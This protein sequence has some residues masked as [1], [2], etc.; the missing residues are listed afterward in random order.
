MRSLLN[1]LILFP[2]WAAAQI[3]NNTKTFNLDIPPLSEIRRIENCADQSRTSGPV[4]SQERTAIVQGIRTIGRPGLPGPVLL[5]D[6]SDAGIVDA[7]TLVAGRINSVTA[8][9]I[10]ATR[11]SGGGRVMAWGHDGYLNA[12]TLD[13]AETGRLMIRSLDWLAQVERKDGIYGQNRVVVIGHK[14]FAHWL[15]S[16]KGFS[17]ELVSASEV[18]EVRLQHT[19]L[20]VVAQVGLSAKQATLIRSV[21]LR[22]GGVMVAGLGWGWLQLNPGKRIQEHPLNSVVGPLGLML[23]DGV[24]SGEAGSYDVNEKL[25]HS[26]VLTLGGALRCLEETQLSETSAIPAGALGREALEIA[27]ATVKRAIDTVSLDDHNVWAAVDR[28]FKARASDHRAPPWVKFPVK[29]IQE[30]DRVL[31]AAD[32]RRRVGWSTGESGAIVLG[33]HPEAANFPGKVAQGATRVKRTVEL[34]R[35][36]HG[37]ISTGLYAEAGETIQVRAPINATTAMLQLQ[38]GSH[39]DKLWH[40]DNWQRLPD[41]VV[42][43]PIN[44]PD[45]TLKNPMGGLIYVVVPDGFGTKTPLQIEIAGAVESPRFVLQETTAEDWRGVERNKPAPWAE[46]ASDKL[47]LTVPSTIARQIDDPAALMQFWDQVIGAQ[48]DLAAVPKERARPERIV[49]DVQ[50]S[51]GYMHSGYP[52]MT[53]MDAAQFMTRLTDLQ[54]GKNAWGLFHE[55]GHNRQSRDWTFDGTT[56]VTVNLFTLFALEQ[57][58]KLPEGDRGLPVFREIPDKAK[59]YWAAPDFSV[60]KSDPFLALWMYVQ[61]RDEFGWEPFKKVFA[62]YAAMK[63]EERPQTEE[64]KRDEWMVRFSRKVGKNLGPFFQAWGVPTSGAARNAIRSL[65]EWMP[66]SIKNSVR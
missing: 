42:R 18:N 52:I 47:I 6:S 59:K 14:E 35:A 10:G 16:Q 19:Q 24:V 27:L 44:K 46:I 15:N 30:L 11:L 55:L 9:V 60:W 21:A 22:G 12:A 53:H 66:A 49:A 20:V 62:E 33:A 1:L 7:F 48:A 36:L 51:H 34:P 25:M 63:R 37:W 50:I 58:T 2:L 56:E 32:W 61:M 38:I 54:F 29:R 57:A 31:F 65:P 64:Q 5:I 39:T 8:P 3:P 28:L 41:V 40:L 43:T 4:A 26:N 17:A 23:G 13:T 45:V